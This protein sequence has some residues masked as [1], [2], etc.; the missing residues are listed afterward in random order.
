MGEPQECWSSQKLLKLHALS[1]T[2]LATLSQL[3]SQQTR[4]SAGLLQAAE[5]QTRAPQP[6]TTSYECVQ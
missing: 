3:K 4:A 6:P 1:L 5:Q 2:K